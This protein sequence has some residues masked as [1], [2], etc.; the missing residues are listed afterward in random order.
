MIVE[1]EG[2]GACETSLSPSVILYYWSFQGNTFVVILFVFYFVLKF[3]EVCTL[4]SLFGNSCSF[5]LRCV[6]LV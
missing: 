6:F 3:C 4:C 1:A 5:D 2:E